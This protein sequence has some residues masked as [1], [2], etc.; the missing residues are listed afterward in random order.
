MML[1]E[2]ETLVLFHLGR[3]SYIAG[4]WTVAENTTRAL[5]RPLNAGKEVEIATQ[6][7]PGLRGTVLGEDRGRE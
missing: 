7:G 6:L 3:G 5:G 4:D 2:R 1:P